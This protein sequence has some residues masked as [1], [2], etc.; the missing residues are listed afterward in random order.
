MGVKCCNA[1]VNG[2]GVWG[3]G[4]VVLTL[5]AR[6]SRVMDMFITTCLYTRKKVYTPVRS[7]TVY[8]VRIL[9]FAEIAGSQVLQFHLCHFQCC[10]FMLAFSML[11]LRCCCNFSKLQLKCGCNSP[12]CVAIHR[13]AISLVVICRLPFPSLQLPM[14]QFH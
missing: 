14:L 13:V 7:I 3:C 6:G 2:V 12:D 5:T 11:Q 4:G 1:I 8:A 9:V 10:N